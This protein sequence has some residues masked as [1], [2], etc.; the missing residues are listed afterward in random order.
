MIF[1]FFFANFIL[2]S[3]LLYTDLRVVIFFYIFVK[4]ICNETRIS[5]QIAFFVKLIL[6]IK[7]KTENTQ[8]YALELSE[9]RTEF[10]YHLSRI[11]F[12]CN[13]YKLKSVFFYY[14]IYSI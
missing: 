6:E 2:F 7:K 4:F 11:I 13:V 9:K 12:A 10:S 14:N 8:L 5:P 1:I 3:L